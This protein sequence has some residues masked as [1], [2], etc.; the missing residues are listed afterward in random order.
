MMKRED[1]GG[2]H[3]IQLQGKALP[4]PAA[5]IVRGRK[6]L[7]ERMEILAHPRIPAQRVFKVLWLYP[8]V[9]PIRWGT[10]VGMLNPELMSLDEGAGTLIQ[11]F[12]S[13]ARGVEESVALA[14][15]H[16]HWPKWL[17]KARRARRK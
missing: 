10:S 8:S 5:V 16:H 6:I 1:L 7:V 4:F 17:R 14:T 12:R 13:M 15:R 2:H 3:T 9:E 11:A